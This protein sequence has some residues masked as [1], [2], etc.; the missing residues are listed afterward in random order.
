M[1]FCRWRSAERN[2]VTQNHF[3]RLISAATC[4]SV[5]FAKNAVAEPTPAFVFDNLSE[6]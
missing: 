4:S 6:K 1:F 2:H 3:W 5:F